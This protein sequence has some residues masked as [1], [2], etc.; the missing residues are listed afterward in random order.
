[1]D[2]EL[3]HMKSARS[4]RLII[5]KLMTNFL[6]L[7]YVLRPESDYKIPQLILDIIKQCWNSDPLKRLKAEELEELLKKLYDDYIKYKLN[8]DKDSLI[9]KQIIEADEINKQL[10]SITTAIATL[11][12]SHSH[13]SRL[14][15]FKNLPEPTNNGN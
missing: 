7:V 6:L 9:Y 5:I 10:P 15:D 1:M 13:T 4:C 11:S 14:L 8:H 3:L 12:I 2:F